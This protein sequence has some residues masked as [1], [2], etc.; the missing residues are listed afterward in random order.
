MKIFLSVITYLIVFNLTMADDSAIIPADVLSRAKL[1]QKELDLIRFEM[2]KPL[3]K[4]KELTVK[5]ADPR[6][7][8]F[9]ALILYKKINH[10]LD[11]QVENKGVEIDYVTTVKIRSSHVYSVVNKAL[12]K[13]YKIK[14]KLKI[15]ESHTAEKMPETSTSSDVFK[16]IFQVNR[17]LNLVLNQQ[18]SESDSYMQIDKSIYIINDILKTIKKE[19]VFI[20]KPRFIRGKTPKDVYKELVDSYLLLQKVFKNSKLKI[21]E[22]DVNK[23]SIIDQSP[24]DVFDLSTLILAEVTY[25]QNKLGSKTTK[26]MNYPGRVLPSHVFQ[27][28]G[29]LKNLLTEFEFHSRKD[30]RWFRENDR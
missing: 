13:I 21:L 27:R 5:D 29:S 8:Y 25:L 3:Q 28:V 15:R 11:E 22:L 12:K 20:E 16:T 10:L 4:Q 26:P 30:P 14:K 17:Q 24:G 2:G 19:E 1:V 7:V 18:A 6:E 9:Q 23:I